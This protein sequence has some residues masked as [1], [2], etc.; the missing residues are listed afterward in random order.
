MEKDIQEKKKDFIQFLVSVLQTEL[1][2][3]RHESTQAKIPE[4]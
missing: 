1:P 4:K 3:E 2:F